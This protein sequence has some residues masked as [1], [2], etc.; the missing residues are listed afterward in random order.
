MLTSIVGHDII[1]EII[2]MTSEDPKELVQHLK[3]FDL[4]DP[5]YYKFLYTIF[6]K[7]LEFNIVNQNNSSTIGIGGE[8]LSS[9]LKSTNSIMSGGFVLQAILGEEWKTSDIDIYCYESNVSLL[10]EKI[11]ISEEPSLHPRYNNHYTE[12]T[13]Y[14]LMDRVINDEYSKIQIIVIKDT[15][16]IEDFI[17]IFDFDV[18][19]VMFNGTTIRSLTPLHKIMDKEITFNPMY[20][21]KFNYKHIER[22]LKYQERGFTIDFDP[23]KL[24][25]PKPVE[26]EYEIMIK[27][28]HL[29][30]LK[31]CRVNIIGN[32]ASSVLKYLNN[33]IHIFDYIKYLPQLRE[34]LSIKILSDLLQL[35]LQS[36]EQFISSMESNSNEI[37]LDPKT[38][39]CVS[40][41]KY[42]ESNIYHMKEKSI[43]YEYDL[44]EIR[45][46]K[47]REE[48]GA[49]LLCRQGGV[50]VKPTYLKRLNFKYQS[51]EF[52][53]AIPLML[54]GYYMKFIERE[55]ANYLIL[56]EDFDIESLKS[57]WPISQ[58]DEKSKSYTLT[59]NWYKKLE[60]PFLVNEIK[61]LAL[62][63]YR[64]IMK[65]EP[66]ILCHQFG[67]FK[68]IECNV[69]NMTSKDFKKISNS[70]D[71]KHSSMKYRFR[72]FYN[73][74]K[75]VKLQIKYLL[76]MNE[77]EL[78]NSLS[79]FNE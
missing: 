38:F 75:N 27:E 42:I 32:I 58:I 72:D 16:L 22:V 64:L 9:I 13:V 37:I 30:F 61:L 69:L 18:C 66:K 59:Y 2:K 34:P 53:G 74:F 78:E 65:H 21:A 79:K 1:L 50:K 51:N 25:V 36:V 73:R 11:G 41:E 17:R 76:R 5:K 24:E 60:S 8:S 31:D 55:E 20:Y 23:A 46:I 35:P 15:T 10:L 43:Y 4:W 6:V 47:D 33:D 26:G 71:D 39:N 44:I 40:L 28:V 14:N 62:I 19:R 77:V 54:R 67:C 70:I 29:H 56:N 63:G 7:Q 48:I 52:H 45:D 57:I 3:F 49:S 68:F 12:L